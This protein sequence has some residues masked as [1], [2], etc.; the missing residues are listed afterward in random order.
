MRRT[1]ITTGD[2]LNLPG[3]LLVTVYE[4]GATIAYRER[5]GD[6][7]GPPMLTKETTE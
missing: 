3:E 1:F 4:E 5:K 2:I 7:W 6:S